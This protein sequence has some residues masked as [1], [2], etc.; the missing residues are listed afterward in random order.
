MLFVLFFHTKTV[1]LPTIFV[2]STLYNNPRSN[3]FGGKN[4]E[5]YF[6]TFVSLWFSGLF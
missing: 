6:I 5:I 2:Q 3:Y 1:S 4:E